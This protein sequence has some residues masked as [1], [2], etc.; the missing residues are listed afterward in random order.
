ML[1]LIAKLGSERLAYE[2]FKKNIL[3]TYYYIIITDLNAVVAF[4][5]A[6]PG[7]ILRLYK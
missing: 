2:I 7:N 1:Y 4:A 6:L 5:T 3:N